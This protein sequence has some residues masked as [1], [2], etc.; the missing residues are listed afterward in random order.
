MH[1]GMSIYACIAHAF[2]WVHMYVVPVVVVG[3]GK[4][5]FRNP[6]IFYL[7]Y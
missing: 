6:S 1:V 2:V 5:D 4:T 3:G 7:I